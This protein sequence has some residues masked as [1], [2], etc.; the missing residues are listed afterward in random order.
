MKIG[1]RLKLGFGAVWLLSLGI[2]GSAIY[3]FNNINKMMKENLSISIKKLEKSQA[4]E[5][6]TQTN[7]FSAIGAI[8]SETED[9]ISRFMVFF[10]N[11]EK[12]ILENESN[13]KNLINI[14]SFEEKRKFDEMVNARVSFG[15]K[16]TTALN[17]RK[18]KTLEE[19]TKHLRMVILPEWGAYQ[20]VL[21][22]FANFYNKDIENVKS[23]IESAGESSMTLIT[24]MLTIS[25]ILGV[26]LSFIITRSI[27]S[28]INRAVD[29]SKNMADGK[30]RYH[31]DVGEVPKDEIGEL[32]NA[33]VTM[34]KN[35]KDI[36]STIS[37]NAHNLKEVSNDITDRNLQLSGR[38]E[39]QAA[40][41]EETAAT[42]EELS[43]AIDQNA[44][45]TKDVASLS[46]KISSTAQNSVELVKNVVNKM[47][48][49]KEGSDKISQITAMI[50]TIAFQTN[51]LALNAAVEAA[52]A[53]EQG[54][55]FAVVA[56]EV[57]VLSQKSAQA[58]K[59]I[60]SLIED[61]SLKI[62]EGNSMANDVE[63]QIIKMVDEFKV[64]NGLIS[65]INSSTSEQSYGLKQIHEAIS[66]IDTVT[67]HNASLVQES[68]NSAQ[69]LQSQGQEL[70]TS[71]AKFQI[72]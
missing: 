66:Q 2:S 20:K 68:A 45:N 70:E 58:A 26:L 56:S 37:S 44:I 30:F 12:S 52:R 55:G 32:L 53:G 59:D 31:S 17:S 3:E 71:V 7:G 34:E 60:K 28:G 36:V 5:K 33:M 46:N 43:S 13:L 29:L 24:I 1:S 48:S 25:L 40:S 16:L 8:K 50:D 19:R 11:S 67:Q 65:Q 62:R 39:Q 4:L 21:E 72:V 22:D 10:T 54:R 57:R 6:F 64:V 41:I 61:S 15:E 42:I 35:I 38:T 47:S 14:N 49:I 23:S 63:T 51:I 27:E 18:D 9:D 69:V